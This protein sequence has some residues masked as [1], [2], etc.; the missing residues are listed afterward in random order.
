VQRDTRGG[1]TNIKVP[2][3]SENSE[4]QNIS[5][6]LDCASRDFDLK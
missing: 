4:A 2:M 6:V 5:S 1:L 3:V